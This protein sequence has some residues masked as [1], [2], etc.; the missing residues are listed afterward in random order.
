MGNWDNQYVYVPIAAVPP[1][2]E[3]LKIISGHDRT[4]V[5]VRPSVQPEYS[6]EIDA[7]KSLH[8]TYISV[9]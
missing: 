1:R 8:P 4:T 2:G 9:L 3:I 5:T 6:M 7:G